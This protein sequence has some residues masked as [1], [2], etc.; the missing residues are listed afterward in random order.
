ML[1]ITVIDAFTD[2]PFSGN[3]AAVCLTDTPLPDELMQK[4]AA[5]M[6]LSETAFLTPRGAAEWNLRWFTPAVE[7]ELC[8]HATLASAFHLWQ[9]HAAH[10]NDVLKFHT[11]SG[12]LT[13]KKIRDKIELDFPAIRVVSCIFP[14]EVV[15]AVGARLVYSGQ[16][17]LFTLFEVESAAHIRALT[18]DLK[19]M[20]AHG[21]GK[22]VVTARADDP[23]FDIVSRFFA[24]GAG[25]DEDPVTGSAHCVLAPYWVEK[26]GKNPLQAYQASK[27]G[28]A[29]EIE[30][31]AD[32]VLLR[33]NAVAVLRAN[34]ESDVAD[35]QPTKYA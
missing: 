31:Q 17:G 19:T 2:K 13:A 32:R 4:I 34:F 1:P 33:G 11:K 10:E 7:I 27:R 9:Q 6:N 12:I 16:K 28:G 26:L 22:F 25:V 24:P 20:V 15:A 8:G 29:L 35:W 5:E 18:P 14:T 30:W 21:L 3:P 23:Q